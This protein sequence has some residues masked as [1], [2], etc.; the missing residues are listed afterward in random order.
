METKTKITLDKEE[1]DSLLLALDLYE[2][3]DWMDKCCS[4]D[5]ICVM[6]KFIRK[7]READKIQLLIKEEE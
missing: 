5:S 2:F 4:D 7:L 6:N 1:I 3:Q